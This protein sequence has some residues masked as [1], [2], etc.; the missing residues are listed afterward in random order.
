MPEPITR[1][2]RE[3]VLNPAEAN[4][5]SVPCVLSSETPVER[6]DFIE[7][8]SHDPQH[9][10]LRRAPFPLMVSHDKSLLNIGIVEQIRLEGG[11]LRGE[12]RFGSS[13]QARQLL[14]DVRSGVIKSLSV[15]YELVR[16]ISAVGRTVRFAWAPFECSIVAVPADPAAGFYR[17]QNSQTPNFYQGKNIMENENFEVEATEKSTRNSRHNANTATLTE[18]ERVREIHAIG[19][20]FDMGDL[21]ARA[22]ENG[23]SLDSFRTQVMGRLKDNGALRAYEPSDIGLTSREVEGYSFTKAILAQT[24]A[25]YARREAGFELEASRAMAQKLGRAPQGLFVPIDV[26]RHQSRGQRGQRDLT[27]GAAAYGGN[28][29]AT[30]LQG[31]NFVEILRNRAVLL[32]LGA[33]TLGGLVGNVAIPSQVGPATASWL[34]EGGAPIESQQTFGQVLLAPKTV[35]AYTDFSRRLLLQS[36]PNIE[37]LVRRDLAGALSVEIDRVAIA[38]S[39]TGN[40]PLGILNASG[41]GAVAV[42]ANGGS[43]TWSHILQLEEGLAN[44]NADVGD[45]LGYVTNYKVRRALKS[46]TK[47]TDGASGFIW[48]DEMRDANGFGKLNGYPAA[49]SNYV[50]SNL[51]KGTGVGLSAVIFGNWSDVLIGMWGGLDIL[52][53]KFSLSTSGGTRVVALLDLDVAI[54][55]VASF[56][57]LKDAVA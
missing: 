44:A 16:K 47:T 17:S 35:G 27:V 53:D 22:I 45:A 43:L 46:T 57:V 40:E 21:A 37:S 39:G 19:A 14:T 29:V 49:A 2:T 36:S 56:V 50:P 12:A 13:L 51:T 55:H 8:L 15:G 24:D 48:S 7:V 25:N 1:F 28:L 23:V 42:G 41:V 32:N 34:P 3:I 26:L 4:G 5:E 38:G 6:G 52:A 9:V 54:R 10:D 31:D 30:D 18:R 20:Q 11:R 33:R